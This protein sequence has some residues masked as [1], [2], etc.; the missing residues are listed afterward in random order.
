M[1]RRILISIIILILVVCIGLSLILIPGAF[2]LSRSSPAMTQDVQPTPTRTLVILPT[3]TPGSNLSPDVE[4]QMDQIQVEVMQIRGL[5]LD[6]PLMRDVLSPAQLK[7]RVTTEFFEEYT[8]EDAA[9]DGLVYYAWGLLD[10]GFDILALFKELYTEQVAGYYDPKT[11]EMYVVQGEGFFGNERLTYAHEFT[12]VL[13]DQTYDLREGM[14]VNEDYCEE[15][16]EYCAA[17]T[18]LVEGDATMVQFTWFWRYATPDDQ[19]QVQES[20]EG[21]ASPVFDTAPG[22]IKEDLMFPYVN[23]LEFAQSLFDRDGWDAIDAAYANPPVSTEQILH[24]DRY[25]ADQPVPV[26]LPDLQTLLGDGWTELYTDVLGEWYT[27]LILTQNTDPDAQL[28]PAEAQTAAA[29]WGGDAYAAY[30][31]EDTQEILILHR[32]LWD[33][34][35]DADEY[36]DAFRDYSQAR[37]GSPDSR[38]GNRL[39]WEETPIGWVTAARSGDEVLWLV[40][41]NAAIGDQILGQ[42]PEFQE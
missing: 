16:S 3:S 36:W 30:I 40:T 38:I 8:P 26:E 13:Q 15:N 33:T 29:G 22:F 17:V 39:V 12:H 24:P 25:P 5:T 37:W 7:E 20:I 9:R 28:A 19:S 11:K 10:P 32:W 27:Y 4:E 42:V 6:E 31:F 35:E 21:Y 1:T 41:P 23:G 14:Q 34:T 2:L 18:A